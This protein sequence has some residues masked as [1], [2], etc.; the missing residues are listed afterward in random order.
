MVRAAR[1]LLAIL[2]L[3]FL[4]ALAILSRI[5]I[6]LALY[7]GFASLLV[8]EFLGLAMHELDLGPYPI[9]EPGR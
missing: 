7:L 3:F 4:S 2:M 1:V 5:R 6:G 8:G 9:G